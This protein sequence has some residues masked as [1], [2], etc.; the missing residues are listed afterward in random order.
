MEKAWDLLVLLCGW[1]YLMHSSTK[2]DGRCPTGLTLARNGLELYLVVRGGATGVVDL[3]NTILHDALDQY[4]LAG[5]C[6][7]E[8]G[9]DQSDGEML[10]YQ[11]IPLLL[12]ASAW[13]VVV[14]GGL[15]SRIYTLR[16]P[17]YPGACWHCSPS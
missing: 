9:G 4:P 6:C 10:L 14:S 2:L 12:N 1:V 13:E 11:S 16:P 7:T 8:R 5:V 15:D 3:M 17:V